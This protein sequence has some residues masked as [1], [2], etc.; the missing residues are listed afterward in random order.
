MTKNEYKNN[1]LELL[2]KLKK[3]NNEKNN[4]KDTIIYVSSTADI[5]RLYHLRAD[6]ISENTTQGIEI[7]LEKVLFLLL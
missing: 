7:A 4:L 2:E 5:V 1:P 3:W 6:T